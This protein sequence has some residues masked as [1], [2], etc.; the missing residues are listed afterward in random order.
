[1]TAFLPVA[2]VAVPVLAFVA[3]LAYQGRRIDRRDLTPNAPLE[4]LLMPVNPGVPPKHP[5][6]PRPPRG[7]R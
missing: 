6:P 4:D 3:L 7:T 1:V 5:N 2:A